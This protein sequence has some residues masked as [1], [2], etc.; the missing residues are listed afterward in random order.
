MRKRG[1][2]TL[3]P[4]GY[5]LQSIADMKRVFTGIGFRIPY[6]PVTIADLANAFA[7][8]MKGLDVE[9]KLMILNDYET[10]FKQ[11]LQGLNPSIVSGNTPLS[12]A[13]AFY[14]MMNNLGLI[15]QK[16][17][18]EGDLD[19]EGD[20]SN[21]NESEQAG[22]G[23]EPE[24]TDYSQLDGN[25]QIDLDM[26]EV[27]LA[28]YQDDNFDETLD[29]NG[30][31]LDEFAQGGSDIGKIALFLPGAEVQTEEDEDVPP[32]DPNLLVLHVNNQIMIRREFVGTIGAEFAN[33]KGSIP[34]TLEI[35]RN[36]LDLMKN[37][38]ILKNR[39]RIASKK[40]RSKLKVEKMVR[41]SQVNQLHSK[42][43]IHHPL[44]ELKL[45]TR[46]LNVQVRDSGKTG[47]QEW[48]FAIDS[49][50][51]MGNI[52]KKMWVRSIQM[53]MYDEV[54]AGRASLILIPY[55]VNAFFDQAVQVKTKE[56]I[57]NHLT[58][59]P[60]FSLSATNIE[61][62]AKQIIEG[63]LAGQVGQFKI[64]GRMPSIIFVQDGDDPVKSNYIPE[65]PVHAFTL[66]QPNDSVKRMCNDSGGSYELF[67]DAR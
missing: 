53:H 51:S 58:W 5:S 52:F 56:D 36:M 10:K 9:F 21:D 31:A 11:F 20:L 1:T 19:L 46:N 63:V 60:N 47:T 18:D 2:I 30:I 4:E 12:K 33:V 13:A 61:N 43:V 17:E 50:G 38:S 25:Q 3:P 28:E 66:G 54:R 67:Y 8:K 39:P 34:E 32:A 6:D 65:I 16:P 44:F 64:N 59:F 26:L 49:S 57:A 40:I 45:A 55:E 23:K 29:E 62:V 48:I 22:P 27:A 41:R 24:Q 35:P 37:L 14:T 42:Q 7:S 15:K